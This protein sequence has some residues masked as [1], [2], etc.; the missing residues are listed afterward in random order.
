MSGFIFCDHVLLFLLSAKP[1][2]AEEKKK[3]NCLMVKT[4]EQSAHIQK[5]QKSGGREVLV[6]LQSLTGT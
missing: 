4:A 5:Q 6:C 1:E 3:M 2:K